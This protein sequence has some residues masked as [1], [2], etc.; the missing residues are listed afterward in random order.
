MF[1]DPSAIKEYTFDNKTLQRFIIRY[2]WNYA[3]LL[4]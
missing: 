3:A 2:S 4:Q 1:M